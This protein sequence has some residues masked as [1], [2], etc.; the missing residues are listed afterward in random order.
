MKAKKSRITHKIVIPSYALSTFLRQAVFDEESFSLFMEN[1]VGFLRNSGIELDSSVSEDAM[2]RLRF[3]VARAH[4]CVIKEKI[5]SAKFEELFG[6][7]VANSKLQD[8]KLNIGAT[9]Q[10]EA[11]VEVYYSEKQTESHRG[12]NTDFQKQDAV[13]ESHTDHWS[14]TKW[15]GKEIVR[16]EDRFTHVP[17]LDALT[18][19]ML[20]TK[21]ES[22][23]NAFGKY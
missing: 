6:I 10:S 11:S 4:D 5:N 19:G 1:S 14:T 17:L 7:V 22:N 16:P 2:I 15:D 18:L 13:T 9:I 23:L 20:I 8:I 3:L 21:M 12:S